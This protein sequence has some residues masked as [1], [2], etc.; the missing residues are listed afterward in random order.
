[1]T[2]RIS[3][4]CTACGACLITC[5]AAALAPAAG[6]PAVDDGRCTDCLACVEVCPADA[7]RAVGTGIPGLPAL[8][9][10]PGGPP[11][12]TV[13]PKGAFPRRSASPTPQ[14]PAAALPAPTASPAPAATAPPAQQSVTN[15]AL[16][17]HSVPP[18]GQS[19]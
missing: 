18:M 19:R 2:V 7:I 8:P 4:A 17:R 10:G 3:A 14:S 16:T 11:P 5:P 13:M 6:R 15:G 9:P 12:P 1:M